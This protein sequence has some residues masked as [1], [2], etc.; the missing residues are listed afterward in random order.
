MCIKMLF[1]PPVRQ[2]N[3]GCFSK[4]SSCWFVGTVAQVFKSGIGSIFTVAVLTEMAAR[5]G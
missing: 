2:K 4:V 5:M 3:E 1:W